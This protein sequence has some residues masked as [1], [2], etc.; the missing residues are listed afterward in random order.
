MFQ[1][2][3]LAQNEPRIPDS[4]FLFVLELDAKDR[5]RMP[6]RR[7][8]ILFCIRSTMIYSRLKSS[9]PTFST[10]FKIPQTAADT[11]MKTIFALLAIFATAS[12][13]VPAQTGR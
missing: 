9:H 8:T 6:D 10:W 1:R 7:P 12:A 5:R 13:F 2:S 11:M 4:I 3:L